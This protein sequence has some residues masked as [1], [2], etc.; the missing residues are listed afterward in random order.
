[1]MWSI[2]LPHRSAGQDPEHFSSRRSKA[3]YSPPG[4]SGYPLRG[5][6]VEGQGRR[7]ESAIVRIFDT[8]VIYNWRYTMI[9]QAV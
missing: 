2:C 7:G 5:Y 4:P 8:K 9:K 3:C 1:M 6:D